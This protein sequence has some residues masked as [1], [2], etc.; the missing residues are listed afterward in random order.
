MQILKL[1]DY[2]ESPRTQKLILQSV[3]D[4]CDKIAVSILSET[5]ASPSVKKCNRLVEMVAY[6]DSSLS[7]LENM[8]VDWGTNVYRALSLA[9]HGRLLGRPLSM[10]NGSVETGPWPAVLAAVVTDTPS[11]PKKEQHSLDDLTSKF[12][13]QTFQGI[14]SAKC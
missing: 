3:R 4:Q 14:V 7:A 13:K 11:I 9:L 8:Y 5:S 2:Y 1:T 12:T 6:A 10:K